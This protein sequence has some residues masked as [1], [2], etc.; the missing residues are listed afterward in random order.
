MPSVSMDVAKQKPHK[1]TTPGHTPCVNE[2]NKSHTNMKT[3]TLAILLCT[4]LAIS[5]CSSQKSTIGYKEAQRY[6]V[7]NDIN[8]HSPR[9]IYTSDELDRY[10]GQATVMGK[11]GAPTHIDFNKS[12]AIAIIEDE[13]NLDTDIKISSI[14][15]DKKSGRITV[16]YQVTQTGAP[17][18]YSTV[19]CLLVQ[20]AKNHG[21]NIVFE[22]TTVKK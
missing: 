2:K 6:F 7:R 19:P 13:T 5:S 16:K 20:I 4:S 17:R 11:N 10:F 8:D 12:N 15:K 3:T 21:D 22:K 9:V 1:H 14:Y 18:S